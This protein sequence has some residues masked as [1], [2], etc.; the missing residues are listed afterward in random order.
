MERG[1]N[2]THNARSL[3]TGAETSNILLTDTPD[4]YNDNARKTFDLSSI[5]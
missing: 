3:Q 2:T 5:P 1:I 4:H